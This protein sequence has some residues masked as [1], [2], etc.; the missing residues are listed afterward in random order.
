MVGQSAICG[1]GCSSCDRG[2]SNCRGRVRRVLHGIRPLKRVVGNSEP[3]SRFGWVLPPL[4]GQ[5]QE[6]V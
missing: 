6:V 5:N 3:I 1:K 2:G 4:T